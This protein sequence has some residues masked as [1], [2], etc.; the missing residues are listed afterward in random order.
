MVRQ[1]K[2]WLFKS[3][4]QMV[5]SI[6]LFILFIIGFIYVSTIDFKKD[7]VKDNEKFVQEHKEVIDKDNVYSYINASDAY[8]YVKSDSVIILFGIK[9][10][11][12]VGHYAN[13]L[14][15][16]AKEVGI[17]KIYY[18]DFTDDRKD[19]NATYE[20]IVEYLDNYVTH[21]DDGTANLY[22]P[23]L[24][25]K[26]DGVVKYFDDDT[27]LIKGNIKADDYWDEYQT[28]LKKLNLKAA[29]SDYV[30]VDNDGKE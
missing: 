20:A 19:K 11:N 24:L 5:V 25:I 30:K 2:I 1:N 28:N 17:D 15:Q 3:Y 26:K 7:V 29:L 18:Y 4:T 22:G 23:T 16:V 6:I 10:S 14:N 21:L 12:W 13:V 27:A 9:D 8:T